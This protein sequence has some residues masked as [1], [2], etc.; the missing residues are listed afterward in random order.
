M[1]S[2]VL[3]HLWIFMVNVF[4]S[5]VCQLSFQIGNKRLK[6]QHKQI[7]P[8]DMQD[9]RD[10][11]QS[12]HNGYGTSVGGSGGGGGGFSPQNPHHFP[13][14]QAQ[15]H[16]NFHGG[17]QPWYSGRAPT[18][19]ISSDHKQQPPLSS[20]DEHTELTGSGTAT[21]STTVNDHHHP[22]PLA[23]GPNNSNNGA[24]GNQN[25]DSSSSSLSPL[26]TLGSLHGAL[27]DTSG[28]PTTTT[29]NATT[30]TTTTTPVPTTTDSH[31]NDTH[32]QTEDTL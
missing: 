9:H 20:N 8:R 19:A 1:N 25:N 14:P 7:R 23:L 5:C 15:Q 32:N 6:V 30:T 26:A 10:Q 31:K 13:L 29:N 2:F 16:P 17:A 4:V 27:P 12:Q 3:C 24:T 22:E 18:A 21:T 28:P 11:Q